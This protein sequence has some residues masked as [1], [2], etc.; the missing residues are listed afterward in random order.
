MKP[1]KA[2]VPKWGRNVPEYRHPVASKSRPSAVAVYPTFSMLL[3][4][5][6]INWHTSRTQNNNS[7]CRLQTVQGLEPR[8]PCYSIDHILSATRIGIASAL[9]WTSY[10]ENL[11]RIVRLKIIGHVLSSSRPLHT[12]FHGVP[13]LPE[14]ETCLHPQTRWPEVCPS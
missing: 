1:I 7:H 9:V 8:Y 11:D 14:P 10:R 6:E 3:Q 2:L 4:R 13:V 5:C 12:A